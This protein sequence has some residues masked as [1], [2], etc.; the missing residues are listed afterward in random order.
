MRIS[1]VLRQAADAIDRAGDSGR[2]DPEIQNPAE[3][4]AVAGLYG[5]SVDTEDTADADDSVFLPPLQQKQE[6]LKR[7]VEVDNVYDDQLAD[8]AHPDSDLNLDTDAESNSINHLKRNAGIIGMAD[9]EPLD[10]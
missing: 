3:L 10:Q 8:Q 9:D 4:D 1:D 2:P 7:A 5:D 6:L